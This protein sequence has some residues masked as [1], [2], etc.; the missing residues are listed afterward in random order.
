MSK[1][2]EYYV[3]LLLLIERQLGVR[4]LNKEVCVHAM[5]WIRIK[6]C[7][8]L[9]IYCIHNYLCLLMNEAVCDFSLSLNYGEDYLS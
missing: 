1:P 4:D 5:C 3:Y 8:Q 6:L 2:C 9:F 7:N